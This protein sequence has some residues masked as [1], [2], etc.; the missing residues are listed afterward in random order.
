MLQFARGAILPREHAT[1]SCLRD[2]ARISTSHLGALSTMRHGATERAEIADKLIERLFGSLH[3]L[4]FS[5]RRNAARSMCNRHRSA[6]HAIQAK[7]QAQPL[8]STE[9]DQLDQLTV[10]QRNVH[11]AKLAS[12][13]HRPLAFL[14]RYIRRHPVAHAIVLASGVRV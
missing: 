3:W 12:Y 4:Q 14:L 6:L 9:N 8:H 5:Q 10:S 11:N 1:E 7:H 2:D 13:A